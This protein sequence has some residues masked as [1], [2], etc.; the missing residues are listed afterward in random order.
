[1]IRALWYA[2][3]PRFG[4]LAREIEIVAKQ[5]MSGEELDKALIRFFKKILFFNTWKDRSICLLE[6]LMPERNR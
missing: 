2:V 6:G 5:T 4:V 3:R 1:L